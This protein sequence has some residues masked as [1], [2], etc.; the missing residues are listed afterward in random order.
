METQGKVVQPH[1]GHTDC[2]LDK[3]AG[4]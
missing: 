1:E 4:V 3:V 2:N